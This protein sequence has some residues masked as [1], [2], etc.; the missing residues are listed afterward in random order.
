MA[1]SRIREGS[2]AGLE[3][4]FK[5]AVVSLSGFLV[6]AGVYWRGYIR[7]RVIRADC[8]CGVW[9][10]GDTLRMKEEIYDMGDEGRRGCL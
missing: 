8:F 7:F 4:L 5:N 9:E 6:A 2:G 10:A 1:R 3:T